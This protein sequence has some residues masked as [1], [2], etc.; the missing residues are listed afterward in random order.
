MSHPDLVAEPLPENLGPVVTLRT[1]SSFRWTV[2]DQLGKPLANVSVEEVVKKDATSSDGFKWKDLNYSA[3]TIVT[4]QIQDQYMIEAQSAFVRAGNIN[5]VLIQE[6]TAAGWYG[7][8][9]VIIKTDVGAAGHA[10][11]SIIGDSP[12]NLGLKSK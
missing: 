11:V 2:T 10:H 1:D 9:K 5:A 12:V 3:T 6:L 8:S 4:G 7:K